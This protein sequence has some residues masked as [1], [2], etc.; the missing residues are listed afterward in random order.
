MGSNPDTTTL[1]LVEHELRHRNRPAARRLAAQVAELLRTGNHASS[2]RKPTVAGTEPTQT[3]QSNPAPLP[4][5]AGNHSPPREDVESDDEADDGDDDGPGEPGAMRRQ[6][7]KQPPGQQ[8]FVPTL[9]R[10]RGSYAGLPQTPVL[11]LEED[12]T[13]DVPPTATRRER[14]VA[15]LSALVRELRRKGAGQTSLLVREG[16]R[17][18]LDADRTA[19]Q[20]RFEG[21]ADNVFEGASVIL[22]IGS[23]TTPGRLVGVVLTAGQL[24]VEVETDLGP[25]IDVAELLIDNTAMLEQLAERLNNVGS[26]DTAPFN[27]PLADAVLLDRIDGLSFEPVLLTPDHG[28]RG[29][30]AEAAS[31]ALRGPLVFIWGPPGTGKTHT[32]TAVVQSLFED[33]KRVI[34]CSN[35]NQAVDQVLLKICRHLRGTRMVAEG[36]IVR[37]GRI[38]HDELARDYSEYVTPSGI[39]ARLGAALRR[40]KEEIEKEMDKILYSTGAAGSDSASICP[41]QRPRAR[42][43]SALGTLAGEGESARRPGCAC[44]GVA[45][46]NS[47]IGA[48]NR[49]MESRRR[50]SPHAAHPGRVIAAHTR[51]PASRTGEDSIRPAVE[52]GR[53]KGCTRNR[54]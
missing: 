42:A 21:E 15:G 9:L 34:I 6:R 28:L 48:G 36:K 20:F 30:Q 10:P 2:A 23:R 17:V 8:E 50:V 25:S 49:R 13:L 5:T 40:R 24:V 31:T 32:L 16:Q 44:S 46:R 41:T 43:G 14:Y 37:L 54:G 4:E 35:T 51:E 1:T 52:R 27:E 45:E 3:E 53:G 38:A 39:A 22:R 47:R 18:P 7:V 29:D 19:Y 33:E 26:P 11:R 12:L